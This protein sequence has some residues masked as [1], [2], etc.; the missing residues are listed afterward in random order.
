MIENRYVLKFTGEMFSGTGS[1]AKRPFKNTA[2]RFLVRQIIGVLVAFDYTVQ[3][4]IVVGAGNFFR[5]HELKTEDLHI[6]AARRHVMGMNNTTNNGMALRAGLLADE[7]V[8]RRRIGVRL[9]NTFVSGHT[10]EPYYLEK[11][12][13]HLENGEIVIV[14]GGI[15]VPFFSTDTGAVIRALE[16]EAGMILKCSKCGIY[17]KDPMKHPDAR[18][19]TRLTPQECLER[20]LGIIDPQAIGTLLAQPPEDRPPIAVFNAFEDGALLRV[21]W[22]DSEAVSYICEPDWQP[23]GR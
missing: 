14:A 2:V 23:S 3:L 20:N 11:A 5:G 13:H 6:R 22:G 8:I 17:D 12:E 1:G 18:M 21:M 9:M 4:M 7:T 16:M 10:G 19:I 15:G